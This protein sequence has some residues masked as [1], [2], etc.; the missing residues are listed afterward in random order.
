MQTRSRLSFW[1][2]WNMSFGFLIELGGAAP[3]PPDPP[4]ARGSE[5]RFARRPLLPSPSLVVDCGGQ[6]AI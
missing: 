4:R 3:H 1:Q 2:V 6:R 5:S